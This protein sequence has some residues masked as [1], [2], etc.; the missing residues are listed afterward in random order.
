MID[1]NNTIAD[2]QSIYTKHEYEYID[3]IINVTIDGTED[4]I[5]DITNLKYFFPFA[6]Y[7]TTKCH[8]ERSKLTL[9]ITFAPKAEREKTVKKLSPFCI[10]PRGMG[11]II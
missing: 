1:I 7:L 6:N 11:Y 5:D 3:G 2:W 8:I 10:S 9:N 4:N